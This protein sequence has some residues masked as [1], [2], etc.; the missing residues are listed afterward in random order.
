MPSLT[1]LRKPGGVTRSSPSAGETIAKIDSD[2]PTAVPA[3]RARMS[4]TT[5]LYAAVPVESKTCASRSN[6]APSAGSS[7]L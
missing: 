4:A 6:S 7:C 5:A 2:A 3:Y 1:A